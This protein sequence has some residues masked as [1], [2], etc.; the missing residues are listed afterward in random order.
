LLASAPTKAA[1]IP[2]AHPSGTTTDFTY[3]NGNTDNQLFVSPGQDPVPTPNGLLFFPSD[4]RASSANGTAQDTSDTLRFQIHVTPGNQLTEFTV[5]EFGVYTI[6]GT[7]ANTAVKAFGGLFLTNLNTGAVLFDTLHTT[8][9]ALSG[10]SGV[11]SGQSAW[12]G[13][14]DIVPI[15]AGWTNIQVVLNNELQATSDAGTTS[16][17]EKKVLTPGVEITL[18]LPE[19]GSIALLA[20]AAA[21]AFG[22]RRRAEQVA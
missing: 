18:I 5:D 4:F 7:G 19:P 20:G 8:P 22:R 17:I 15:P 14:E 3:D 11:T 10:N 13:D 9:P 6:L 21:F 12:S 2:W 16:F 1:P